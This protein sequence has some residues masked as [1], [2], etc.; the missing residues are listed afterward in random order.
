MTRH[1]LDLLSLAFGLLF[2]IVGVLLLSGGIDA[3]ALEWLAPLVAIA[4]GGVLILAA[5]PTRP[6]TPQIAGEE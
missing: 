2:A 4:I 1:P 3:L 5:R 6:S